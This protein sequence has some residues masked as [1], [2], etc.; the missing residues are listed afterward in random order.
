MPF[1]AF[2]LVHQTHFLKVVEWFTQMNANLTAEHGRVI[3][4]L[5][6][7]H[8]P[9]HAMLGYQE[10]GINPS[11]SPGIDG[12]TVVPQGTDDTEYTGQDRRFMQALL[13]TTGLI[14]T[15]SG[16]DHDNDWYEH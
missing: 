9:A 6:F 8:I 4:S 7:Y 3:P 11:T 15:F 13:N 14:G 2:V 16:H 10:E 5:A 12:E 1:P